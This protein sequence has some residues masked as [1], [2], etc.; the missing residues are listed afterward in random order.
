MDLTIEDL[1]KSK[2]GFLE[3][4]LLNEIVTNCTIHIF[5]AGTELIRTGQ[6]VKVIPI[7]LSGLEA[8]VES[9]LD[10]ELL[11]KAGI[12]MSSMP[13]FAIPSTRAAA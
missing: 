10:F 6:Y 1:V 5:P 7:V 4:E 8:E 9:E 11:R 3:K 2:L 13:A 12:S